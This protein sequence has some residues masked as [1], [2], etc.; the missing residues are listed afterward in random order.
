VA[1]LNSAQ[2]ERSV[3]FVDG[4]RLWRLIEQYFPEST[5]ME[6]LRCATEIFENMHKDWRI[7]VSTHGGKKAFSIEPKHQGK[8]GEPLIFKLKVAFGQDAVGQQKA[9]EWR[10]CFE[11]GTLVSLEAPHLSAVELPPFLQNLIGQVSKVE[12]QL[13][14][15]VKPVP[16]SVRVESDDG[17]VISC[18]HLELRAE[19]AG[20]KEVL[21]SNRHQKHPW[22][23]EVLIEAPNRIAHVRYEF[24]FENENVHRLLHGARLVDALLKPGTIVM[25]VTETGVNFMRLRTEAAEPKP[26]PLQPELMQ[27][28][29]DLDAIQRITSTELHLPDRGFTPSELQYV[30]C[31]A[32]W[33]RTG[34]YADKGLRVGSVQNRDGAESALR[35]NEAKGVQPWVI[36]DPNH[37][38]LVLGQEV[39][40]GP[41]MMY[42]PTGRLVGACVQDL[43]S[44]L[45]CKDTREF[46]VGFEPVD[47]SVVEL[48][49]LNQLPKNADLPDDVRKSIAENHTETIGG[50]SKSKT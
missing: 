14:T 4:D 1:A 23:F 22:T 49:S 48:F 21:M 16:V 44:G 50:E 43:R 35:K 42:L 40:I 29:E 6:N 28:L 47:G 25:D 3:R 33:L 39:T 18:D 12:F 5:A 7:A 46:T 30:R 31:V 10:S 8:E 27:L 26:S 37:K 32:T 45:Q 11:K 36:M 15:P 17:A 20:S 38:V 13:N 2:A 19:R 41:V 34:R 24:S 9:Q